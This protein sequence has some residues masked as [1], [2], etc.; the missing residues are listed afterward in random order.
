MKPISKGK[1]DHKLRRAIEAAI[2]EF[3]IENLGND[4]SGGLNLLEQHI[5]ALVSATGMP[6]QQE[7]QEVVKQVLPKSALHIEGF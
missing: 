7:L 3:V 2:H 6:Q 1:K 5:K 4:G